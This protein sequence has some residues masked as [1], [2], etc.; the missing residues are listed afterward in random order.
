MTLGENLA[1]NGGL[2]H[3]FLAYKNYQHL[4]GPEPQLPG[5][6]KFNDDQ[7]FFIAYGSVNVSDY[8]FIFQNMICG[9][10]IFQIWCESRSEESL[11]SQLKHD[12]HCPNPIR[13]AGTIQNSEDFSKAFKCSTGSKMNPK[14]N[15]CRIW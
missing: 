7:I 12:E 10:S 13:V 11:Q 15:K 3:A 9:H 1:D 4:H 14:K 8:V 5:F 6:E 2:H